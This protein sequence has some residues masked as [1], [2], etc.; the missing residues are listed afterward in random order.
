MCIGLVSRVQGCGASA[1]RN[2]YQPYV[3]ESTHATDPLI[4]TSLKNYNL[5]R[6]VLSMK[7]SP[8][9]PAPSRGGAASLAET[10][11]HKSTSSGV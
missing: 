9:Q 3:Q 11:F 1:G 7:V 4:I 10:A 5:F 8:P 2:K 6:Y